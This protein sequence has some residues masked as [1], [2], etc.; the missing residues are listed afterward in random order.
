MA[1]GPTPTSERSPA[2]D[3]ARGAMLLLIALANV[4]A[5]VDVPSVGARGYP[6]PAG[7]GLGDRLTAAAQLL[8]IDG[9][10]YPLFGLLFGYGVWQFASRRAS[11]G[12][13]AGALVGL[14]RRRSVIMIVIG[15]VHGIAL[16]PGDIIGAYGLILAIAAG[17]LVSGSSRALLGWSVGAGCVALVL[18]TGSG[19]FG[20]PAD[21][22][23]VSYGDAVAAHLSDW[24]IGGVL[25]NG[26]G[27]CVTVPLG[28]LAA[29][30]RLLDEPERHRRVLVRL[31]LVGLGCSVAL[32]AWLAAVGGG[33]LP[34]PSDS[35]G[36]LAGMLHTLGGYCGGIAY[37]ALF[38]L[39]GARIAR[40]S[41]RCETG[42]H[43]VRS[44]GQMSMS[45][46]LWQSVCFVLLVAPYGPVGLGAGM[47]TG[48]AAA[49]AAGVWLVS[50]AG[51]TAVAA[52]GR[53]GPVE[54]LQRRWTYGPRRGARGSDATRS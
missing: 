54:A 13:D 32:G 52:S 27:V 29:R 4:R 26:I 5:F 39:L 21:P 16:F 31:A 12:L 17:A 30:L 10:A 19:L 7:L 9:R 2:P 43:P 28:V 3:L 6:D 44:L 22:A 15:A 45:G 25:A 20:L 53:R 42:L 23:P 34:P 18:S 24:P 36:A 48:G 38:G 46:Y 8:L 49:L 11:A 47:S 41:S 1:S 37:A 50:L 51:A 35:A 33:F 14:L 40:A